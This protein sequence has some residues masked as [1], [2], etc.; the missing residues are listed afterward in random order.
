MT[1]R[2]P[3]FPVVAFG[4]LS[5]FSLLGF[6]RCAQCDWLMFR[7][8]PARSGRADG[9][10]PTLAGIEWS[11]D[12]G[13]PVDASPAVAQGLVLVGTASGVFHARDAAT[14]AAK[15]SA[16]I[17]SA[18]VSS[19]CVAEGRVFFGCVDGYLYAFD[20]ATG[21]EAWRAR[22]GRS[23]VASPVPVGDRVLCG[24]TDGR[25]YAFSRADGSYLW[26]TEQGGEVQAG[27]A[28]VNDT[29]VYADWNWRVRCVRL[30]DGAPVWPQPY[31]MEGPVV[32][33]PVIE[34]RYVVVACLA[35]TALSPPAVLNIHCLDLAT[36]QRV[37]GSPGANPWVTEK[38]RGPMSVATC[39]TVIGDAL[40]FITG[41]GYGN[42]S[43][44]VRCAALTTGARLAAVPHNALEQGWSVTDSSP[45]MAGGSLYF[46][47]YAGLLHQL[48]T[49]AGRAVRALPLGA[50][51]R[52]SPAVSD[53]RLYL[54]LTD[55]KLLCVR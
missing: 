42:W 29:V 15:W 23:I 32:A 52:S 37:W 31:L 13:G 14:G 51:T 22:T 55:G 41:E 9:A 20:A 49:T 10:A 46:A 8:D 53:G 43:A 36:G 7:H 27:A 26:R 25:L 12:L 6:S 34:G 19:P 33:C 50:R 4:V 24:S 40:W 11:V 44:M 28:V 35:P 16:A 54:G 18:L 45:A 3:P 30:A 5:W 17:G 1:M 39:P 38:E 47:D 2:H 48:D 21:K